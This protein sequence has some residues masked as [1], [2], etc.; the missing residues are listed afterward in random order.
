MTEGER[1]ERL[2]KGKSQGDWDQKYQVREVQR[3]GTRSQRTENCCKI[4]LVKTFN[5]TLIK[6][7]LQKH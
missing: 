1:R 5:R 3:T 7:C 4:N 6:L 2:I